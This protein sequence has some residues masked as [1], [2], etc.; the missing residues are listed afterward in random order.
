MRSSFPRIVAVAG[1]LVLVVLSSLAWAGPREISSGGAKIGE[2]QST[3]G[4]A[5]SALTV[6]SGGG[7]VVATIPVGGNPAGVAYNS[8]NGYVYVTNPFS[9]I[10]SVINGTTVVATVPVEYNPSGVAYDSGNGYV[11][12]ANDTT[13]VSVINGTTV[14]ATVP[15]GG[16]PNALAYDS[17][18]GYVYV[19]NSDSQTVSVI[20]GTV[21]VATVPVG[22]GPSGVAYDSGN[23]YVYVSN[24]FSSNVSVI[25]GTTNTVVATVP[26]GYLPRGVAYDSENMYVYVADYGSNNVSVIDGTTVVATVPVGTLPGAL[27]YDGGNGF[28][29]VANFGS[30][31][32]SSSNVS[33]ISGTVVVATVPVGNCPDGVAYDS[34]NGYLYVSNYCSGTVSVIS[35]VEQPSFDFSLSSPSPGSISFVRGDT[36][37]SSSITATLTTGSAVPVTITASDL[38]DGVTAYF[39]N[40]PCS[41]TCTVSVSF[42]ATE[43]VPTGTVTVSINV[44]GGGRSHS[45]SLQLTVTA[46]FGFFLS[47]PSPSSLIVV[48]G[49]TSPS[50]SITA[51]LVDGAAT[52]TD[53]TFTASPLPTGIT[54]IFTNN[55]CSPTCTV[56]VGFSA[57]P[58]PIMD[59]VTTS[60]SIVAAGGGSYYSVAI[61]LMVRAPSDFSMSAGAVSPVQISAGSQG[62]STIMAT[63]LSGFTGTVGLSVSAS[64]PSGLTCTLPSSVSFGSSPQAATLSCGA[65][66]AGDYAVTVTGTSGSLTHTTS[67][68]LFHVV[69]ASS[70]PP[71]FLGL[72]A[73]EGYALLAGISI[74]VVAIGVV[75]TLRRVRPKGGPPPRPS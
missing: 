10:V 65:T 31:Y 2:N 72:P 12:V 48:Q 19:T 23:G 52:S 73:P 43:S 4:F 8:G 42:T 70:P 50:S 53:V 57:T 28:V 29:Y 54:A 17:E 45:V 71:S 56:T 1:L 33:V 68:I 66:A 47:T 30:Y 21:V 18:N 26:V 63:A 15:V 7:T 62:T 5:A 3:E 20:S 27:A 41:P 6:D 74:A 64:S 44:T 37:P 61:S 16:E 34:G 58:S 35:A 55:P 13:Y 51:T 75:L 67:S 9:D 24:Y 46:A 25:D 39:T 59:N 11:Y 14:V 69:A 49:G 40:N 32:Y 60:I 38:P 36:S 22:D